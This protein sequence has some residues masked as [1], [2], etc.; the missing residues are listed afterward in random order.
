[1]LHEINMVELK[2]EKD[3]GHDIKLPNPAMWVQIDAIRKNNKI[4][5]SLYFKIINTRN[6]R[7]F[8]YCCL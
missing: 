2:E 6:S 1:M 5:N 7:A 8:M 3:I 4:F